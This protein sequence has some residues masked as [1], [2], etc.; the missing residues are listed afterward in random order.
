MKPGS[1]SQCFASSRPLA[2]HP[3]Q[4]LDSQTVAKSTTR[5]SHESKRWSTGLKTSSAK[6]HQVA[7]FLAQLRQIRPLV[8]LNE[9]ERLATSLSKT[10][11]KK[12]APKEGPTSTVRAQRPHASCSISTPKL[13]RVPS[14]CQEAWTLTR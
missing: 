12:A 13:H 1:Y 2:V 6:H 9:R 11:P 14:Q 8:Q 10:K 4:K 3:P 5:T 7:A